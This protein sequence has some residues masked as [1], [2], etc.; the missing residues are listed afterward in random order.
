MLGI[1]PVLTLFLIFPIT[2][3]VII[4]LLFQRGYFFLITLPNSI[5]DTV[6]FLFLVSTCNFLTFLFKKHFKLKKFNLSLLL[7]TFFPY[8]PIHAYRTI[9]CVHGLCLYARKILWLI[10][11]LLP[12]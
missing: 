5:I 6:I 7:M 1:Y 12:L 9:V 3:S 8:S 2:L 11:S 10:S 4:T